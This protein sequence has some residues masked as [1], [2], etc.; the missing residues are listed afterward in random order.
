MTSR[1][2]CAYKQLDLQMV[3][4]ISALIGSCSYAHVQAPVHVWP[5]LRYQAWG[6]LKS[7][8]N[9]HVSAF[10][11][12]KVGLPGD[13]DRRR[14]LFPGHVHFINVVSRVA[15]QERIVWVLG[16]FS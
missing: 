8:R 15:L 4:Q 10:H 2:V 7:L 11:I 13:V 14:V 9:W 5:S 6:W 3:S 1:L 12:P 16:A